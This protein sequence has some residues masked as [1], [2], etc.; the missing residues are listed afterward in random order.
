MEE[1]LGEMED[2]IN[3]WKLRSL[4]WGRRMALFD[5]RWASKEEICFMEPLIY[6]YNPM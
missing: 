4:I 3:K 5:S 1:I 6:F 2:N